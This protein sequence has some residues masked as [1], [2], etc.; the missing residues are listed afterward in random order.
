MGIEG[1]H[2]GTPPHGGN[3][4]YMR[5]PFVNEVPMDFSIEEN[6]VAMQMALKD[7]EAKLGQRYP[8]IING[9]RI[10]TG[11]WITSVN[12]GNTDQV[13]G[14]VARAKKEHVDQTI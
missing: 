2:T 11:D 9:E 8:L 6:R 1:T 10:E 12:P 14:E 4:M 13:V 3:R 5:G 7:V